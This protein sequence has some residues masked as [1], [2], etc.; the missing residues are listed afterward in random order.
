MLWAILTGF[1]DL[2]DF[3]KQLLSGEKILRPIAR[4]DVYV[5]YH[6]F[7][8]DN[9][10]GTLGLTSFLVEYAEHCHGFSACVA[11]QRVINLGEIGEGLL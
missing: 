7:F 5:T 6:A 4:P 11:K 10:V 8:I 2:F 9:H 1:V 3:S